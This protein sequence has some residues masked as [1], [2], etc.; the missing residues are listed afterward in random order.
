MEVYSYNMCVGLYVYVKQY[1]GLKG[2]RLKYVL[3]RH[4]DPLGSNKW[5]CWAE[6]FSERFPTP[7]KDLLKREFRAHCASCESHPR[8]PGDVSV[9]V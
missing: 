7:Q 8:L 2:D 6:I 5:D 3:Y 4:L 1:F 9:I